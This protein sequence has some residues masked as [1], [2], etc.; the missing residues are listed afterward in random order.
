MQTFYSYVL[1][2]IDSID[3]AQRQLVDSLNRTYDLYFYLM[4]LIIEV[5]DYAKW[6]IEQGKL[7]YLP[8]EEDLNPNT[9][10]IENK[11]VQQLRENMFL[12]EH[13]S[14]I[15]YNWNGDADRE[16]IKSLYNDLI[17]RDFYKEFMDSDD[18]SYSVHKKVILDFI[19]KVL[20]TSDLLYSIL[21]EKNLFWSDLVDYEIAMVY[22]TISKFSVGDDMRKELMPQFRSSDD[23]IFAKELLSRTIVRQEQYLQV[24]NDQ[25]QNWDIKRLAK[26]DIILLL[27]AIHE[28]L[29]FEDIPV[30]VTLDEYIDIA[31]YYSTPKSSAFI[32]GILDKLVK[33]FEQEQLLSKTGRGL[34]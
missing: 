23:L 10:F 24:L 7:K 28:L 21:E 2:G 9:K 3:S 12:H 30:K 1:G 15:G 25:V 34:L 11:V 22:K 6:K 5:V 17:S 13:L 32:N 33:K 14:R 26:L 16:L 31:K 18:N 29:Y 8:T 20:Y 4:S 19:E 27:L